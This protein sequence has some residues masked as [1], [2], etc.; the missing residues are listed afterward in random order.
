MDDRV[1][2][3]ELVIVAGPNGAG[4]TY[5]TQ[6]FYYVKYIVLC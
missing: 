5:V 6:R 2:K 4:K 1:R 3:P